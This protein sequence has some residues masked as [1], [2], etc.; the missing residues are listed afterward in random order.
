MALSLGFA[1]GVMIL[2]SFAE[3]LPKGIDT[4]GPALGYA[5]FFAGI[6]AMFALDAAIPHSY[7]GVVRKNPSA[8]LDGCRGRV[9][10]S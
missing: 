1:A 6:M 10:Y 4:L 9:R 5:A 7:E 2:V 3:L 8:S